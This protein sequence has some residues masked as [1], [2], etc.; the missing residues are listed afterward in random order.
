MSTSRPSAAEALTPA[1]VA[2]F[3]LGLAPFTPEPHVVGKLRWVL[4]G[5][6][7]M[8]AMDWGDLVLHAA[9]WVWLAVSVARW[10]RA[11]PAV[12][13]GGARG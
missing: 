8:G 3:T 4:G 2:A 12:P 9:P 11:R 13:E 5:A 10:L 1:A 7:G 6:A